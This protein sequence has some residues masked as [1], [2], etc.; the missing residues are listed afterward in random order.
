MKNILIVSHD[1]SRTG[2]PILLLRL[3]NHIRQKNIFNFKIILGKDGALRQKFEELGD[4]YVCPMKDDP[5]YRG[6]NMVTAIAKRLDYIKDEKKFK[7][8]IRKNFETSDTILLNSIG[9]ARLLKYLNGFKGKFISY[10]HELEFA[11]T[12]YAQPGDSRTLIE[13][14][15][16]FLV[17]CNTVKNNLIKQFSIADNKI[18]QLNY[19]LEQG[20]STAHPEK[21]GNDIIICSCGSTDWRKGFDLLSQTAWSLF[22][23]R[24]KKDFQF[25]WIGGAENSA[26]VFQAKLELRNMGISDLVSFV[27]ENDN[28]QDHLSRADLFFLPSKE[29]PYPVVVLEAASKQIP[30]ICFE[31]GGGIVEFVEEDAG[32]IVPFMDIDAVTD[33]IIYLMN[34][35]DEL[36]QKGKRALEKLAL[37]HSA[38]KVTEQLNSILS[39]P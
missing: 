35:Q 9:S 7:D 22:K 11:L 26:S 8:Q 3:L 10:I 4:T 36:K 32:W 16:L 15:D 30:T 39:V 17:P 29:D 31:H 24:K 14:T 2:A 27:S 21:A 13:R 28:V 37:R 5:K 20:P 33:K 12:Y 19:L 25:V 38:G 18:R 34:N 1:A 23:K 6:N